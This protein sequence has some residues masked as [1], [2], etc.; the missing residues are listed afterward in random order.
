[1]TDPDLFAVLDRA[2]D[3]I[4]PVDAPQHAAVSALNRARV[5][6]IRRRGM[7]AGAVAAAAVVAVV[8]ATSLPGNDRSDA[9][10][11]PAPSVPTVPTVP[12]SAVQA[13]W[14][15]RNAADLPQRD[16]ILPA[17]I[18][19]PTDAGQLPLSGAARLVLEDGKAGLFLLG[20]DDTWAKAQAPSGSAYKS[21]LSDD[22]TM[23]ANLGDGGLFVTDVSDGTWR[24]LELPRGPA[25]AWTGLDVRVQWRGNAQ[26]VL[27]NYG[28]GIAVV[29][30]DGRGTPTADHFD[31][32]RIFGYTDAPDGVG[33]VFADG[34]NGAVIREVEGGAVKR[35]FSADALNHV[36]QPVATDGRVA[37]V[38]SGIPR[39]DR[40]TDHSGIVV[41]ERDGYAAMSYL[42]IART[43]Y[44]PGADSVAFG[45]GGV[46]PIAWLDDQ[47]VLLTNAPTF[48]RPWSLVA[49][50]VE[51]GELSLVSAGA[52]TVQLVGVAR[53]LVMD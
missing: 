16:S 12:D 29:D 43:T 39:A 15:P 17:T 33:L 18:E 49:W 30:V 51:S 31:T 26:L 41:L 21:S 2:T 3:R 5:V 25:G 11:D 27:S 7:L 1:M 35:S 22:G 4:E 37:G 24:R 38:V 50:D 42:P 44:T 32:A 28:M 53:D 10:V 36:W 46:R 40:P 19:P 47:T 23:L 9:P 8:V 48:G 14:E 6:R 52:S 13:T 45:V 20:E 34:G